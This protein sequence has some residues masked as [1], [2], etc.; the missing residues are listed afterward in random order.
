MDQVVNVSP[1]GY[2]IDDTLQPSQPAEP[3]MLP[4]P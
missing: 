4:R 3:E 1:L 2:A